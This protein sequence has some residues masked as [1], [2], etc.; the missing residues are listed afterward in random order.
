MFVRNEDGTFDRFEEQH[1]QH[2]FTMAEV[3]NAVKKQGLKYVMYTMPLR[4]MSQ[5]RSQKDYTIS[6]SIINITL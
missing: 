2:G 4:I 5:H 3:E 6:L 1:Y